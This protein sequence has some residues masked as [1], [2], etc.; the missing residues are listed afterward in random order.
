MSL[1]ACTHYN[2]VHTENL[3][4]NPRLLNIRPII[5]VNNI[6]KLHNSTINIFPRQQTNVSY[7][8]KRLTRYTSIHLKVHLSSLTTITASNLILSV[9]V[10][11]YFGHTKDVH[12]WLPGHYHYI[13]HN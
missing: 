10:W 7:Q 4:D 3:E 5:G 11:V 9:P 12:A 2:T 8:G 13:V 6:A 1:S